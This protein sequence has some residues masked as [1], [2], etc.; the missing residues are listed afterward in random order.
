MQVVQDIIARCTMP[1]EL[2]FITFFKEPL[3]VEAR[4]FDF[5]SFCRSEQSDYHCR[6]SKLPTFSF[7]SPRLCR[8]QSSDAKH[9]ILRIFPQHLIDIEQKGQGSALMAHPTLAGV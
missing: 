1:A 4:V 5:F 3:S 7:S 6:C 9:F 2:R 8:S